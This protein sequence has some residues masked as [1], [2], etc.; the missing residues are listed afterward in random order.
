MDTSTGKKRPCGPERP[1]EPVQHQARLD[2]DPALLPVEAHDR[3]QVLAE[4]HDERFAH[5][6]PALRG[7]GAAGEEGDAVLRGN[8]DDARHVGLGSGDRDP[9]GLSIW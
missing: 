8:G 7:A 5:G 9:D 4:V 3:V 1:V 6:L 2:R